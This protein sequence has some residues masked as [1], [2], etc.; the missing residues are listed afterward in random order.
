MT[1]AAIVRAGARRIG[2]ARHPCVIRGVLYGGVILCVGLVCMRNV[3]SCSDLHIGK[4]VGREVMVSR[5]RL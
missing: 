1:V 2:S 5:E 4:A 3:Q